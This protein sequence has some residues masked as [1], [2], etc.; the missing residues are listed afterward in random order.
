MTAPKR[1][2][3]V[4][5]TLLAAL[6]GWVAYDLNWI[7]ERHAFLDRRE[8]INYR[9]HLQ[10]RLRALREDHE[11]VIGERIDFKQPAGF[12]W[13]LRLFGEQP[14]DGIDFVF[15]NKPAEGEWEEM[16]LTRSLFPEADLE[17]RIIHA[18]E[19]GEPV[20]PATGS[21]R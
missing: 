10:D 15:I 16:E 9:D 19:P 20:P 7:R 3:L 17:W 5:A 6:G 12:P 18:V 1:R 4:L 11:L 14:F 21:I 2:W 13:H 8:H